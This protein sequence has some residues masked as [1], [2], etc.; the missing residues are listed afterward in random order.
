MRLGLGPPIVAAR[1]DGCD[2]GIR[3]C[4]S[5]PVARSSSFLRAAFC[6]SGVSSGRLG[7]LVTERGGPGG[8][9]IQLAQ[10]L[11][12]WPPVTHRWAGT[13]PFP[14]TP[15]IGPALLRAFIHRTAD[16]KC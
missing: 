14:F 1:Y 15:S 11:A 12:S 7:A 2:P 5:S 10:R 16:K 4:L 9:H 3:P 8:R 13:A 6:L